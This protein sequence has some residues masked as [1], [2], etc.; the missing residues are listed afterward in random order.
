[1]NV[2]R[3]LPETSWQC[4]VNQHPE[5]NI[6]HT[7]EIFQVF[8]RAKRHQPELWASTD[9]NGKVLALFLPIR[10]TLGGGLSRFLTARAVSY[11]GVLYEHSPQGIEGL[12]LLLHAYSRSADRKVVFTELRNQS[13]LSE[14]QPTLINSG[15]AFEDH[16]NFRI[17]LNRPI[18]DI[19]RGLGRRTR[20]HIRHGLR[21]R[22]V[23]IEEAV[24]REQISHCYEVLRQTYKTAR[25]P[26]ADRSLFEAAYDIL[27]PLG[28]I[29]FLLVRIGE[30]YVAA[31]VELAYKQIL[32]GWYGGVNREYSSYTPNELLTWHVLQ[33][34]AEHGYQVYDFGGAGK[35]DEPYGVRDFK[36]K[37]G[38]ELVTYGRNTYYHAPR[39]F[40]V[41]KFGYQIYRRLLNF[42]R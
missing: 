36:A 24:E 3:T 7:P 26:L 19:L 10:I 11:G 34:G 18:E 32:Y 41:S 29:K 20:K 17:S 22:T 8:Q 30:T 33:W 35:P 4:F 2:V 5:S 31:S 40:A 37:F 6:F 14:I 12:A 9:E 13:D 21:R 15:F 28:M 27:Y 23:L 1:M 25:V 39:W 42:Q 38:G 16:L